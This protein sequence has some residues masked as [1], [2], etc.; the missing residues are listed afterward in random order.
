MT[1]T[2]KRET[3]EKYDAQG[4]LTGREVRVTEIEYDD[5]PAPRQKRE[6]V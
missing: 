5:P 1:T 3:L 6:N 2:I 4:T